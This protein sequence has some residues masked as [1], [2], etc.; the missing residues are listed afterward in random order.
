VRHYVPWNVSTVT[1]F[2]EGYTCGRPRFWVYI[3][4]RMRHL[5]RPGFS[6]IGEQLVQMPLASDVVESW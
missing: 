3:L 4:A 2:G 1:Q 5:P 6:A